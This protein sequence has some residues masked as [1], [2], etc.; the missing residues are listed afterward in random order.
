[1]TA[2]ST[3][4]ENTPVWVLLDQ[5]LAELEVRGDIRITGYR[6]H[7]IDALHVRIAPLYGWHPGAALTAWQTLRAADWPASISEVDRFEL[8]MGIAGV[9]SS[10]TEEH[11][12]DAL[13]AFTEHEHG[14]VRPATEFL[15][16]A[17]LLVDADAAARVAS[18]AD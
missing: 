14:R 8:A 6:A 11:V 2:S 12:A 9:L 18:A 7:V 5:G 13:R 16:I 1:M 17:R 4:P 3:P 15:P 10:G